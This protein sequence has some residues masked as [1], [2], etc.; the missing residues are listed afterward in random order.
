MKEEDPGI[1]AHVMDHAVVQTGSGDF[2]TNE[3]TDQR[4]VVTGDLAK[5][6]SDQPGTHNGP[7]FRISQISQPICVSEAFRDHSRLNERFHLPLGTLH[8]E[9]PSRSRILRMLQAGLKATTL[10]RMAAF[11]RQKQGQLPG[12]RPRAAQSL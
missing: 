7:T 6:E 8:V 5:H 1:G 11:K 10:T 2:Q 9:A 3:I 4:G 12:W